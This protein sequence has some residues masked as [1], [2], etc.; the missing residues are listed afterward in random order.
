VSPAG[1]PFSFFCF[2]SFAFFAMGSSTTCGT[3]G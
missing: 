1:T 2:V 3:G